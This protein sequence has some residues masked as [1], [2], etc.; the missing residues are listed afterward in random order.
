MKRLGQLGGAAAVILAILIGQSA[1]SELVVLKTR[2]IDRQDFYTTLWAVDEDRWIW[3]RAI[4]PNSPWL[5]HLSSGKPVELERNGETTR[6]EVSVIHDPRI[7]RQV[8]AWMR[9]KYGLADR[10]RELVWGRDTVPVKLELPD[11]F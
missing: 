8:D 1:S 11:E 2:D 6:Y 10:A 9:E 4:S 5:E 7:R 3:L